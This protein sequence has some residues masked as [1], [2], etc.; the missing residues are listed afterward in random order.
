MILLIIIII[1]V[2]VEK[3]VLVIVGT[4]SLIPL[5]DT[6]NSTFSGTADTAFMFVC[7]RIYINNAVTKLLPH[8][9]VTKIIFCINGI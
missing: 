8:S 4:R 6:I 1:S 7:C 3:K 5:I 2:D 9:H